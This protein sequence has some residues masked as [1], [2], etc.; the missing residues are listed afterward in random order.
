M[1]DHCVDTA[2]LE[3][4]T[5]IRVAELSNEEVEQPFCSEIAQR[6]VELGGK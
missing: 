1:A 4:G 5:T 3:G 2:A 6:L